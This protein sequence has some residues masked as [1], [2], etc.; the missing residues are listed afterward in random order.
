MFRSGG[1]E[2]NNLAIHG[3]IKSSNLNNSLHII[4]TSFEHPSVANLL[5]HFQNSYENM[6]ISC[7]KV[8]SNGI[9]DLQYF[10]QLLKPQTKLVTIVHSNNEIDSI[11]PIEEIVR[12]CHEY[13]S[14]DLI[15][16]TDAS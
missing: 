7:V 5:T 4:P 9:I 14:S 8:G 16:H 10:R 13:G 11:Q 3:I 2:S 6:K 1:T 12:L 15:I